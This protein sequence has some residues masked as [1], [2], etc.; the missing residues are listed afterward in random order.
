MNNFTLDSETFYTYG[1]HN[2]TGDAKNRWYTNAH[3][4]YQVT[5]INKSQNKSVDLA[6]V[7][8]KRGF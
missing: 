5:M 1:K 2:K 3:H 7:I 4:I 8:I 6:K